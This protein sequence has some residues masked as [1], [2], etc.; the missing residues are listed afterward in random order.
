MG[1][2]LFRLGETGGPRIVFDGLFEMEVGEIAGEYEGAIPALL[3][4]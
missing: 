3:A 1:V 4:G 2:H